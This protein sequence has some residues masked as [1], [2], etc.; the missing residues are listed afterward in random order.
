M[1]GFLISFNLILNLE[2]KGWVSVQS[3]MRVK[4]QTVCKCQAD[5]YRPLVVHFENYV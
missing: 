4:G 1:K 3:E 5:I 2:T